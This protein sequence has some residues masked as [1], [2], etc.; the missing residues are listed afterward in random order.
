MSL[1][2]C[3]AACEASTTPPASGTKAPSPEGSALQTLIAKT[4]KNLVFVEGGT[5]QMGDFGMVHNAAKLP[6][7]GALDTMPLHE[8]KLDSFSIAAYKTTYE[9]YDIYT[10][11]TGQKKIAQDPRDLEYKRRTAPARAR[12]QA[13]RDYCQWLGKQVGTPM[14]LPTEAQWEYAARNRGQMVI[15]ATD[16]GKIDAGRNVP[17]YEWLEE[18]NQAEGVYSSM[19]SLYEVGLFPPSPLGLYDLVSNGPDW[20]LDWYDAKYY[21][22]SPVLNPKGPATGTQKVTRGQ[23]NMEPVAMEMRA[24]TMVRLPIDPTGEFADYAMRCVANSAQ[25]IQ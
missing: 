2:L 20:T 15:Y 11:A 9:D 13:A 14:D 25:K 7:Y 8:V 12:W 3:L 17:T 1:V 24:M 22:N 6:Y 5:F 4:K 10:E 19:H 16:N 23:D 18:H 21:A